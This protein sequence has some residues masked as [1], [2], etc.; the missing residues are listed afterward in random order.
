MSFNYPKPLKH[1]D[2]IRRRLIMDRMAND[3]D[4]NQAVNTWVC[5]ITPCTLLLL[6]KWYNQIKMK[7]KY[8][9]TFGA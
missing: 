1:I 3:I 9:L 6:F 4:T 5:T 7:L 2:C 8:K